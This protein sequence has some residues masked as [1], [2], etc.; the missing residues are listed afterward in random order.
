MNRT[1]PAL[2]YPPKPPRKSSNGLLIIVVIVAAVAGAGLGGY[3]AYEAY[4]PV[5]T[6]GPTNGNVVLDKRASLNETYDQYNPYNPHPFESANYAVQLSP[7]SY[8]L[9]V[10]TSGTVYAYVKL[11]GCYDETLYHCT[12]LQVG[13]TSS[14]SPPNI[15]TFNVTQDGGYTLTVSLQ[16]LGSPRGACGGSY[17]PACP[18]ADVEVI[19]SRV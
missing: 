15:A 5:R 18:T 12:R 2:Y 1:Q 19:V 9:T 17:G 7:G 8:E 14:E 13:F 10:H 4:K 11:D 16:Q 6:G 3:A